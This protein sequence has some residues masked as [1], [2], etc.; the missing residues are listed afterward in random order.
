MKDS[1]S[2]ILI[3]DD[4]PANLSLLT[5]ILKGHGYKV[6][7]AP[8]GRLALEAARRLPPD[9]IL[10][11]I[12]MPDMDGYAV[13]RALKSTPELADIPVLFIS[14]LNETRDKLRAFGEGG[15]DYI[16]KPFHVEEV[17]AR[18]GTHLELRRARQELAARNAALEHAL[19]DL[20]RA[21]DHLVQSEK[22]AALGV[23]A[24]GVA[25]EINNPLN[26]IKAGSQSLR[27]DIR[28]LLSLVAFC[29]DQIR[30]ES[31]PALDEAK[32]KMDYAALTRELDDLSVAILHGLSRAEDIV[33]GL[34]VFARTDKTM[35]PD[36]DVRSVMDSALTMLHSRAKKLA[37]IDKHYADV[38]LVTGNAGKLSQVVLNILNNALDAIAAK[39]NGQGLLRI[40]IETQILDG[41]PLVLLRV[42]DNGRG[43][44]PEILSKICDP[45]FTTKPVGKGTG[46]GLF[47]CSNLLKEHRGDLDVRSRPETGTTVTISLP[48]SP[49]AS[50]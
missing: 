3:V 17:L 28:D 7:P 13:C 12:D 48:A 36:I 16:T 23:M 2:S 43:M 14:A 49:E 50:C 39:N 18:V 8:N 37:R 9:L 19:E 15:Q 6:R 22:M 31:R 29:E 21:Q 38:P 41:Q 46:L 26:F 25:H 47:I 34:L 4:V 1:P 40:D 33:N 44:T 42:T 32:R 20:R 11:D 45:F 24:A 30:P 5:D 27:N 10:L 35:H